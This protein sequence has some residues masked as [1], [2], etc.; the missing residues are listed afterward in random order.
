MFLLMLAR[1]TFLDGT[2]I[3][4]PNGLSMRARLVVLWRLLL[5]D[6]VLFQ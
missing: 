5:C 1:V 4:R 2:V 6:Q 3:A